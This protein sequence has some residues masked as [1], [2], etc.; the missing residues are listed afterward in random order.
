MQILR[1]M[2]AP[3]ALR[4][5]RAAAAESNA[6]GTPLWPLEWKYLVHL[7][8]DLHPLILRA[9]QPAIDGEGCLYLFRYFG[10]HNAA[11][12]EVEARAA[13]TLA[14]R[15]LHLH[16]THMALR[17]A[18]ELASDR[19]SAAETLRLLLWPSCRHLCCSRG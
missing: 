3:L 16:G 1:E 4:V 7:P 17:T 8:P 5:A 9:A 14:F 10:H 18:E 13:A 2:S 11:A 12:A 6:R 19:K 15:T